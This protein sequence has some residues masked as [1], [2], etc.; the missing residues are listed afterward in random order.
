MQR[1]RQQF[2]LNIGDK[3]RIYQNREKVIQLDFYLF[4]ILF[5]FVLFH[6]F[7]VLNFCNRY[8]LIIKY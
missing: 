2:E 1:L 7:I 8:F 6:F 4:F 5:Y 3:E